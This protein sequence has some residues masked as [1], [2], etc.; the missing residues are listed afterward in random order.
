MGLPVSLSEPQLALARLEALVFSLGLLHCLLETLGLHCS[1][2]GRRF[3]ALEVDTEVV[4]ET[5]TEV[6]GE[7]VAGA[8][9]SPLRHQTLAGVLQW[10]CRSDRVL[11]AWCWAAWSH[12]GH[13]WVRQC[14]QI[15]RA[16]CRGSWAVV[17]PWT[18]LE[19]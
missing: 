1:S 6:V 7:V 2:E 9:R 3:L 13:R 11:A 15:P 14:P 10:L 16:P 8:V 12:Q 5:E 17:S 19:G 4:V 18:T